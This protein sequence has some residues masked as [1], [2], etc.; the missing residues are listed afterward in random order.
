MEKMIL[1][2]NE[3][4]VLKNKELEFARDFLAAV[5]LCATLEVCAVK[6]LNFKSEAR[7]KKLCA[8]NKKASKLCA[9]LTVKKQQIKMCA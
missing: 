5:L 8:L 9:L 7:Y 6:C 4:T 1:L 3:K 2:T